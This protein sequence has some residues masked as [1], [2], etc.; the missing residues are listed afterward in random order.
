MV[1]NDMG[2]WR[3]MNNRYWPAYYLVDKKGNV[4]AN[5]VGETH[6]NSAQANNIEAAIATL[7]AEKI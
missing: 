1:D 4:R 3:K 2:F 7:L 6:K 5:Y